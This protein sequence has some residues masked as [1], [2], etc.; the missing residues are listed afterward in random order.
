MSLLAPP[1]TLARRALSLLAPPFCWGC[2]GLVARDGSPLCGPCLAELR[3]LPAEPVMLAGVTAWA[4]LAY[5]G[6]AAAL[7]RALKYRGARGLA[8]P[9]AAQLAANA[10]PPL[11][12]APAVLVPVPLH[13]ARRRRRGYNQAALLADAL[14]Q[15]TGLEVSDCLRRTGSRSRQVGRTREQ[16]LA[17]IAS[18]IA[19]RPDRSVPP[20]ALVVD[21]VAT[22]GAT[23]AACASALRA[24]GARAVAAVTFA[25][26]PG[27]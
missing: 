4:P 11:L 10:P 24:A 15:R 5:E 14:A 20:D 8:G 27:R 13:P 21:D 23:L 2:G 6:A 16:R 22:T 3:R 7:A 19:L 25:R 17:G 18:T 26:T 12:E 1:S 9:M